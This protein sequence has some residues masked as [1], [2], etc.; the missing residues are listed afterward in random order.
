MRGGGGRKENVLVRFRL[1]GYFKATSCKWVKGMAAGFF[2]LSP[3]T[4][5][6][7]ET[8]LVVGVTTASWPAQSFFNS[9]SSFRPL[10]LDRGKAK[11]TGFFRF[12]F[13]NFCQGR[14]RRKRASRTINSTFLSLRHLTK[15]LYRTHSLHTRLLRVVKQLL[16]FASP[17]IKVIDYLLNGGDGLLLHS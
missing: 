5:A 13:P 8:C 7:A 1:T 6:A 11:I 4:F 17:R 15:E 2:K 9:A 16:I 12:S 10:G 3:I 14:Y